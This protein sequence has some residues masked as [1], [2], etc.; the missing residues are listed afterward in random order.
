MRQTGDE[1]TD[2][3]VIPEIRWYEGSLRA[4]KSSDT[5]TAG[6]CFIKDFIPYLRK[7]PLEQYN[8]GIFFLAMI[9]LKAKMTIMVNWIGHNNYRI[10]DSKCVLR[11]KIEEW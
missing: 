1:W 2:P 8:L 6:E 11:N 4:A 5:K 9:Y 10:N 7:I 3:R